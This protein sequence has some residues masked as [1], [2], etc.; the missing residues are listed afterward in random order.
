[1]FFMAGASYAESR[2]PVNPNRG[3]RSPKTIR[4]GSV[5]DRPDLVRTALARWFPR[6]AWER[7][8]GRSAA[9]AGGLRQSRRAV[10]DRAALQAALR[11][12]TRSHTE[13]GNET[14]AG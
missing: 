14:R 3:C 9:G 7:V 12:R 5:R 10:R 4:A 1:M 13:R 8:L 11:P 6:R 2:H